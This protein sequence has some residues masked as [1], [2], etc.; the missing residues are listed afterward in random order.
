MRSLWSRVF[1]HSGQ[2][3]AHPAQSVPLTKLAA[4]DSG[5]EEAHPAQSVPM[6]KLAALDSGQE[7]AR[8]AQSVPLIKQPF[9]FRTRRSTSYSKC[10][11]DKTAI[12]DSM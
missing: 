12:L 8:P 9:G 1:P 5:Q 6:T 2:K 4:L 11:T 7:E 3:E 10:V